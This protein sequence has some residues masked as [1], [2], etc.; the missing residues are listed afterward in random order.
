MLSLFT[1]ISAKETPQES[2]Q[3]TSEASDDIGKE[4]E[5]E[6]D[7][8][9]KDWEKKLQESFLK[10]RNTLDKKLGQL[11]MKSP[12]EVFMADSFH[13]TECS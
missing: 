6:P 7:L 13:V 2:G 1:V 8:S 10:L 12:G 4:T 5:K 3:L 11:E 9:A